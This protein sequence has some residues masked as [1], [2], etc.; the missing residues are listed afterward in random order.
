[1]LAGCVYYNG[2]YNTNR[3][4]RSARKAERENKPFEA[5]NLWGQVVTRAESVSVRHP[6]SKY[7]TEANV[8]RGLALSRLNQC[9]QAVVPLGQ[10]TLL[11]P[12]ELAEEGT[13]ALGRCQMELGDPAGA[14]LAF[15]AIR[16][17]KNVARRRE[18]RF[19]HARALRMTG[20]YEEAIPLLQEAKGPRAADE[21]LLALSGAGRDAEADSMVTVMLAS[22]DSTRVWDSL[23]VTLARQRPGSAVTLV[24]RLATQPN[25]AASLRAKRLYEEGLRLEQVDTAHAMASLRQAARLGAGTDPGERASLLLLRRSLAK[26]EG[27]E[28]LAP[29]GDSLR[30]LSSRPTGAGIEAAQL[31]VTLTR[32]RA[33]SDSGGAEAPKGDM[34]LFLAAESARDTLGAPGVAAQ[35]FHRIVAEWPESPYAP[36]AAL[37]SAA[38]DS[39]WAD[40]AQALLAE[41]YSD[42]PYLAILRGQ[43]SEEYRMLEDSLLAFAS[44]QPATRPSV[45]GVRRPEVRPGR[46]IAPRRPTLDPDLVK[47]QSGGRR[48]EQ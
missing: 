43:S 3:L 16:D 34:R 36:K 7:A 20:H 4:M 1:L 28:A 12:G 46:P 11:P 33:S 39:A 6:H 13:L 5:S 24:D 29:L 22:G 9:Q 27:I 30:A 38:L 35:L 41:R 44:A 8:V 23:V 32:V 21:L 47:D 14:D 48:V 17:S 40:S 15:T 37:A 45:P 18:A 10:V 42:S 2:M 19:E 25:T 26:A 31:A